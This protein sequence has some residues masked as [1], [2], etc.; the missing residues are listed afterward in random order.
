MAQYLLSPK[1]MK[2]P[3]LN[4][5]PTL[6]LLLFPMSKASA[7]GI[8]LVPDPSQTR[9]Q[10]HVIDVFA[11]PGPVT[12][13][14]VKNPTTIPYLDTTY[15][16]TRNPLTDSVESKSAATWLLQNYETFAALSGHTTLFEERRRTILASFGSFLFNITEEVSYA[17]GA[18]FFVQQSSSSF[19]SGFSASLVNPI[20][21]ETIYGGG[22]TTILPSTLLTLTSNGTLAPG[23]YRLSV[24]FSLVEKLGSGNG[25]F[26]L[27]LTG[28]GNSNSGGEHVPDAGSTMTLM[29]MA[30]CTLGGIARRIRSVNPT[31]V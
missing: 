3:L 28:T 22:E 17:F 25:D 9:V 14:D 10:S 8:N 19:L 6:A 31:D 16:E 2:A 13:Q 5:L 21:G 27:T 12:F 26:T 24:G 7:I 20:T 18:S 1:A 30:L 29:G 23:T 4:L 15:A 11:I